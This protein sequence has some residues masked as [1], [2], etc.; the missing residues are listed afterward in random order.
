M[1]DLS[2]ISLPR[3]G[4]IKILCA[5]AAGGAAF[6]DS[7]V[8]GIVAPEQPE[9]PSVKTPEEISAVEDLMR[10]HSLLG[11]M[12]LIYE[13]IHTR[14]TAGK[15]FPVTAL[16]ENADIIRRFVEDYHEKL[17]EDFLFQQFEKMGKLVDLVR[18]LLQQHQAGRRLTDNIK[19]LADSS[20]LQS[21]DSRKKLAEHIRLF[22]RMY[23]PHKDR[24]G[25]VLFPAI[26]SVFPP[27]EYDAL[28]DKFEDKERQLFGE[29]GFEKMVSKVADME[30]TLGIYE[31]AQFT[32][33][34]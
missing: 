24:E 34:V 29:E 28:G 26:H 22:V 23:R 12:L 9:K 15:E 10:E 19:R 31:L 25:T 21:P 1:T 20:S 32:P 18:V 2:N 5:F 7:P 30:K 8:L 16:A 13:E 11:R 4:I 33:T 6:K 27:A 14:L 3:R 17:E